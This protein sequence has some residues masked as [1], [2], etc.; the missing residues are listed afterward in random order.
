MA[1]AILSVAPEG[2]YTGDTVTLQGKFLGKKKGKLTLGDK[3]CKLTSWTMDARTGLSEAKFVVPTKLDP[4]YYTLTLINKVGT[5]SIDFELY[6][7]F[8]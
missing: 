5:S 3:K 8:E 2:G 6:E 4:G 7:P 1:P